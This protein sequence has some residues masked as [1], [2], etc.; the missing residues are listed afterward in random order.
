MAYIA[1]YNHL[2]QIENE[3][4]EPGMEPYMLEF[5]NNRVK[6]LAQIKTSL[7]NNQLDEIQKKT[8]AWKGFSRPFGFNHLE[9]LAI[10]LESA[11]RQNDLEECKKLIDQI[12]DYLNQKQKYL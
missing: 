4:P 7:D 2:M 5:F 12:E 3:K 10:E 6:E 11:V 9:T 8:H 1:Q